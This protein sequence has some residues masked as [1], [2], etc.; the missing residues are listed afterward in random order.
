MIAPGETTDF[1]HGLKQTRLKAKSVLLSGNSLYN[2]VAGECVGIMLQTPDGKPQLE[3][4]CVR[5]DKAGDTF[6]TAWS[7]APGADKGEWRAT[8]GTG[9]Y[10]GKQDSGWWQVL[11][12]DAN[13]VVSKW[14]G[15]CH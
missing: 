6:S 2:L 11:Y 3:G 8:G 10:A 5:H 4:Y 12:A 7:Q 13:V 9:K 14:G 15:D 1:G